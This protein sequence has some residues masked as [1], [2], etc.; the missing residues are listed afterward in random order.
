MSDLI[1]LYNPAN[2]GSLSPEQISNLQKLDSA[3]IKELADAYPNMTM[4]RAYLLIIDNRRPVDKQIP[5]L[6]SFQNLWNLREKNSQRHW[7]AYN[8]R[9]N[10]K[11]TPVIP[12]KTKKPEVLDLSDT[13]LMNLPG[14]KKNG[15][16]KTEET[17]KVTK[18]KK[19][20]KQAKGE[21]GLSPAKKTAKTK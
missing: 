6:S 9:G 3:Q 7:V 16:D 10:Y 2:A 8:F 11:Q 19:K 4:S 21:T 18:V 12:A 1:K 5:A 13:E 14:F 20:A 15:A 17:V